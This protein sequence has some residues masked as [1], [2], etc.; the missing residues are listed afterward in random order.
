VA[1]LPDGPR[2]ASQGT[3]RLPIAAAVR[4]FVAILLTEQ[5]RERLAAEAERLQPLARDIAWVARDNLHLTL[6]FLGGVEAGRLDR[7]A[8]VLAEAA[9]GLAAFDLEVRDLGAFPSA[10]RPRVLWAGIGAGATQAAALAVRL[11]TA[12]G[13]L[14]FASESRPFSAHVTLARVRVPR[15]NP[16][17][18]AALHG[19]ML[20]RQHVDHASFMRSELWPGGARYSEL[21]RLPLSGSTGARPD[22]SGASG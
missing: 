3:G 5:I 11:D 18:A 10:T 21:A 19:G 4:A 20:G 6:K 12:L 8:I 13:P 7:V 16:P 2:Y 17:L 15:P 1:V 22:A 14:G 9:A